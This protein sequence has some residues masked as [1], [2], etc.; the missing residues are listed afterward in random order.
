M[1]GINNVK[2]SKL[3]FKELA[4]KFPDVYYR[5]CSHCQTHFDYFLWG[6]FKRKIYVILPRNIA[7]LDQNTREEFAQT[8]KEIKWAGI[9][10]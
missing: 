8:L 7:K 4:S 3:F 1:H 9:A 2:L 6:Y 10:Q 5:I